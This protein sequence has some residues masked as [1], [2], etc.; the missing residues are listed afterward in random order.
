MRLRC[1]AHS[2]LFAERRRDTAELNTRPIFNRRRQ[3]GIELVAVDARIVGAIQVGDRPLAIG[4]ADA[5]MLSADT[6]TLTNIWR[7]IDLREDTADRILW[8]SAELT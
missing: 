7:Q 1:P 2:C 4:S 3:T 5:R 6:A 8:T